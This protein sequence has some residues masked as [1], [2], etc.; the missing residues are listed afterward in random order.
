LRIFPRSFASFLKFCSL[1]ELLR[2]KE[3]RWGDAHLK[4]QVFGGRDRWISKFEAI[5]V[6]IVSSG[7]RERGVGWGMD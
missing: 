5:L 1:F 3:A 2:Y 4:A 7:H 6:Y